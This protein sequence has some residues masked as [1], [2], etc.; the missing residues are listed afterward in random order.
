MGDTEENL[1]SAK[2]IS[3]S[4]DAGGAPAYQRIHL[5]PEAKRENVRG[6]LAGSL[7]LLLAVVILASFAQQWIHPDRDRELHEW[8]NLVFS[9]LVAL[10]G[11]ATGFYFGVNSARRD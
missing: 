4:V 6:L 3:G 2:Q 10:V 9:P 5:T 11:A 1:G 8:M 7:V